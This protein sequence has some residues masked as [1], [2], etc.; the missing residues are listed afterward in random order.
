MA[1][2]YLKEL[3]AKV[4]NAN[5]T[6]RGNMI[7]DGRYVL[8][9]E[10]VKIIKGFKGDVFVAEFRVEQ[11]VA[12][13]KDE[14]GAMVEPNAVGSQ[15]S[16]VQPLKKEFSEVQLKAFLLGLYGFSEKEISKDE[17]GECFIMLVNEDPKAVD[18][19]GTLIPVN[20]ARGMLVGCETHRTV[21][22]GR[23]TEANKGKIMVT[24]RWSPIP[25]SQEA[26][27]ARRAQYDAAKVQAPPA[28]PS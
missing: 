7:K 23:V 12:T 3:A 24:P 1:S 10:S 6:N 20:P 15:C 17:I 13:E 22:Q 4:A 27:Q 16:V 21:N 8:G 14:K 2:D 11:A 28:V 19:D 26:V 18:S 25:E 9:V 5:V